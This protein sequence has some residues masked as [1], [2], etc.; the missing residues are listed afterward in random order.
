M[1][2]TAP[3]LVVGFNRPKHLRILLAS[4]A[5][6]PP[7]V[8][9]I[10][11]DGPRAG[12]PLD[13]IL[14]RECQEVINQISIKS[15]IH[16]RIRN[17]NLGLK[18]SIVDAVNWACEQYGKVIVLED[19]VQV[20]PNL[21]RFL[22]F[23]LNNFKG[24]DDIAHING[25]NLVPQSALTC[26]TDIFRTTRFIESYAWATWD[27]AWKTYD[28]SLSWGSDVPLHELANFTGGY[29]SAIKWKLNFADAISGRIDTWA[30]RWM[31]SIWSQGKLIVSPNSNL[32]NYLGQTSGTHTTL[33][34]R[35][36][37]LPISLHSL[38]FRNMNLPSEIDKSADKWL[39]RNVFDESLLG[40]SKGLVI[41]NVLRFLK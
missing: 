36:Q 24:R 13:Q 41:S 31:S 10:A 30:Y 3:V 29:V 35:W 21:F 23:C 18:E 25:Y 33:K 26:P 12:N 22:N 6:S 2:D 17:N 1:N 4:I 32:I 27:R 14:V 38:D 5:F 28:D 16:L 9:L 39:S 19:D 15:K 7:E 8:L 34:P 11:L 40:I 20:G 37:E